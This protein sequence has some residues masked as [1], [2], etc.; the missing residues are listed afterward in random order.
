MFLKRAMMSSLF[1]LMFMTASYAIDAYPFTYQIITEGGKKYLNITSEGQSVKFD[2]D[3][4]VTE[5]I[6]AEL[7]SLHSGEMSYGTDPY[8]DFTC[9]ITLTF[10][11]SDGDHANDGVLFSNKRS[12]LV[13]NSGALR[14]L[15]FHRNSQDESFL[16]IKYVGG[17]DADLGILEGVA[18]LEMDFNVAVLTNIKFTKYKT[19]ESISGRNITFKYNPPNN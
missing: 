12:Y 13:T 6:M 11:D 14:G 19:I 2:L 3:L 17:T 8:E 1:C 7:V 5:Y 16:R 4:R 18:D 15:G 9:D 10:Y